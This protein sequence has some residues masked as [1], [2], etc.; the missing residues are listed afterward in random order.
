MPWYAEC[1]KTY[2]DFNKS[3]VFD[4]GLVYHVKKYNGV[5]AQVMARPI[6][7]GNPADWYALS[8]EEAQEHFNKPVWI[9]ASKEA[10][11][12]EASYITAQQLWN[13]Y[14]N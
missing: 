11:T 14:G 8:V 5:R 3:V 13:L 7:S 10:Y 1:K 12:Q 9:D 2:I 4:K 6:Q